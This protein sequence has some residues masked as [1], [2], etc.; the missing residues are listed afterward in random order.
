MAN[1]VSLM[2]LL[3]TLKILVGFILKKVYVSKAS[4]LFQKTSEGRE[5]VCA[6]A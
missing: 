2:K 3:E 5:S 4:K 1:A 6:A